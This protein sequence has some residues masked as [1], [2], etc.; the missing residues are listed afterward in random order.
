MTDDRH[1]GF[2]RP[3]GLEVFYVLDERT[4]QRIGFEQRERAAHAGV[5]AVAPA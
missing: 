5:D 4:E 3:C 1:P 2:R